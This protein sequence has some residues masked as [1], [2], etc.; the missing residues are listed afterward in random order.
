MT[1]TAAH[2]K[3]RSGEPTV[4]A[5]VTPA[6]ALTGAEDVIP[7][8][9]VPIATDIGV[10]QAAALRESICSSMQAHGGACIDVLAFNGPDGT[11][12]GYRA[13]LLRKCCYPSDDGQQ[14]MAEMLIATGLDPTPLH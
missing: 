13:G 9:L 11:G 14:L 1:G 2:S 5:A 7:P 12:D 6:N 3:L 8:Y 10:H 4:L